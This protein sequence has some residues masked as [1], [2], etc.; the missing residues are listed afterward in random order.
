MSTAHRIRAERSGRW[1]EALAAL[2]LQLKGYAILGRRVQTGLGEIDVIARRGT[3]LAFI[4]VKMR[5]NASDPATLLRSS[6][7][8]RIIKSATGWCANRPWTQHFTWRY[9][10][11]IVRQWCWPVHM[12]D[13]WRPRNDP[14]LSR[15][16]RDG[17]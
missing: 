1:A 12:R 10:L 6:Q 11:I 4:E 8:S 2:S 7:M 15:G 9:D 17:P 14:M 13:A 5:Q 16:T 3:V